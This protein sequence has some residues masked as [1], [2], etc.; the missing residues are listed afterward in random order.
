MEKSICIWGF[1]STGQMTNATFRTQSRQSLA[2]TRERYQRLHQSMVQA[3]SRMDPVLAPLNAYVLYRK[4]SPN[5]Q[6]VGSLG[7]EMASI[8]SDVQ[9]LIRDIARSIKEADAFLQV[10]KSCGGLKMALNPQALGKSPGPV[11]KDYSWQDGVL[12]ALG[13]GAGFGGENAP[14]S[15]VMPERAPDFI[16]QDTPS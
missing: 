11:T 5:A 2:R 6:A 12:Y 4:H 9:V 8:Q 15:I 16:V 14:Q 10:F 1:T 7:A 13:V 3:R